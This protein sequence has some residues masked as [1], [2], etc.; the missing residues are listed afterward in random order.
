MRHVFRLLIAAA[1]AVLLLQPPAGAQEAVK[2]IQLTEKQMLGY[3]AAQN[4]LL[5]IIEKMGAS[6]TPDPKL[7]AEFESV[8]KKHGFAGLEEY[9]DVEAN[10]AL[11]AAGLDPE[12][13][14]FT[15]PPDAIKQQIADVTADRQ[16]PAAE[17]K[18]I[19]DELNEM[20]KGVA[21]IQ[22]RGNIELVKKYYD[23]LEGLQ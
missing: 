9:G 16:I 18:Q 14:S 12:T 17:K 10:I 6:E 13:K 15:E 3:L 2:Q 1:A 23:K 5:P 8:V 19:L 4:D 21:P 7:E 20:L 22:H 11:V